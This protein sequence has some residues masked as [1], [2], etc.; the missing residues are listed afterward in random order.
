MIVLVGAFQG[1]WWRVVSRWRAAETR[2]AAVRR[3]STAL[4]AMLTLVGVA[5]GGAPGVVV[6][7]ATTTSTDSSTTVTPVP[8]TAPAPPAAIPGQ[9]ITTVKELVAKFGWPPGTDFA[10]IRIPVVGV[11]AQVGARMVG[12]DGVMDTPHGPADVAWYDMS[13]WGGMGGAP[14]KGRNAIFSGHVDYDY[15]VPYAK[16][17]YRGDGVFSEIRLLSQGDLIDI[18]YGGQTLRYQ[19]VWRKQLSAS[20]GTDWASIWSSDVAKDSI[21]LFTCGGAFDP[22]AREYADRV[23]VR[24]ERV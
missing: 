13:L 16:V 15:N 24:A 8:A 21:T 2:R 18:D 1:G 23:V 12:A 19:V 9:T 6:R 10:R 14:G 17:P 3:T 20:S 22:T 4:L 7:A 5:C 11:D